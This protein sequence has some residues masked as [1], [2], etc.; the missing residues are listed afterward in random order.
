MYHATV[1]TH[2]EEGTAFQE[3]YVRPRFGEIE[4]NEE[5]AKTLRHLLISSILRRAPHGLKVHILTMDQAGLLARVTEVFKAGGLR[6]TRCIP[7][8][9]NDGTEVGAVDFRAVV[10]CLAA[11]QGDCC[12]HAVHTFSLQTEQGTTPDSAEVVRLLSARGGTLDSRL[13]EERIPPR[14]HALQESFAFNISD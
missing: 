1:V 2:E 3:F 4:F 14:S 12:K 11:D 13:T 6:V 9:V 7:G 5:K 8:G 10:K